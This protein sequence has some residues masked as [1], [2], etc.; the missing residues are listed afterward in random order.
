MTTD[1]ASKGPLENAAEAVST[2][3]ATPSG[4]KPKVKGPIGA[5]KHPPEVKRAGR[6]R[7]PMALRD[8]QDR[9]KIAYLVSRIILSPASKPTPLAR[10]VAQMSVCAISTPEEAIS[11]VAALARGRK[12]SVKA[13]PGTRTAIGDPVDP[14]WRTKDWANAFGEKLWR[15]V[16]GPKGL[17]IRLYG[18]NDVGSLLTF[19]VLGDP[20]AVATSDQ[21]DAR[22]LSLMVRSWLVVHG[23]YQTYGELGKARALASLAGEGEHFDRFM[24]PY[25]RIIAYYERKM[26]ELTDDSYGS[27]FLEGLRDWRPPALAFNV[28]S[29]IIR[30]LK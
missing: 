30:I 12:V 21:K 7:P 28:E 23:Y 14:R 18:S 20:D 2:L 24:R 5:R 13:K 4:R 8:D 15:R 3:V 17:L 1:A 26:L 25:K 9:H 6:G 16:H 19:R 11:F 27:E 10:D 29:Q 22:W